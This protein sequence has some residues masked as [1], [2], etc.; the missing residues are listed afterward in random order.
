MHPRGFGFVTVND[1]TF[2]Q[3]VFIP[4]HLTKGAMHGD[5]VEISTSPSVKKNKGPE[6]AVLFVIERAQKELIG[7]IVSIEKNKNII[8]YVH[9][10]GPKRKVRMDLEQTDAYQIADRIIM[11]ILD[12]GDEEK[13]LLCAPLTNMGSINKPS[14]D[15]PAAIKEFNLRCEFSK[16]I[17][18]EAKSFGKKVTRKERSEREDFTKLECFTI[19]PDT[20]KDFDDALSIIKE[21]NGHYTL[22]VHIADVSHYVT[23][24]SS[25]DEEARKRCN[26]TYLPGTCVPM[27][28]EML[29][30][31]L[32]SLKEKVVR[33][34]I[35]VIINFDSE[36]NLLH[37]AIKRGSIYSQKRFTY[38]EAKQVLDGKVKSKHHDSLQKMAELCLLLKKKR[39]ERGCIDLALPEVSF[40][41][42]ASG[43]PRDYKI[44]EYDI[45]H[46]L[47]EE[48]MLKANEIVAS[49]LIKKGK[50]AI[51]RIHEHP[52][53]DNLNEFYALVRTFGFSLPASPKTE[54][55]Q[56]LF[57]QAKGGP[58]EQQV[59]VAFV[60]SMKLAVYSDQNVGHYGL[61]LENYCHFTSPIRRYTDLI[62]HR[63]LFDKQED[64]NLTQIATECSDQERVSFR[65]ESSVLHL[66]KLRYFNEI[67]KKNPNNKYIGTLTR[68]KP[69][70]LFFE[71]TPIQLEGFIHISEIGKD[72]FEY[73]EKTQTLQ[74]RS[75]G[76]KFRLGDRIEVTLE[77]IDLIF[78]T[79]EWNLVIEPSQKYRKKK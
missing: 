34:C 40:Q 8:L 29:S 76:K 21:E 5:L 16:N 77:K 38:S 39:A 35:S 52:A 45:T 22:G 58:Y 15:I 62:I 33:L 20:A 13:P 24:G 28:P 31:H 66:K 63:L 10:L 12:W 11:E 48:F 26:S 70:G 61:S 54:D 27:L 71:L 79:S 41:I 64:L 7:T 57:A 42:D 78:Q 1:K 59:S 19:D 6:G 47:V 2:T 68:I 37:Y 32:C 14:S 23:P 60:R 3:D 73:L 53:N 74:G 51:F 25:L 17:L 18:K 69:F 72:Y 9:S 67:H 75:T 55:L 4:K 30:N 50:G 36:G 46:Q 44:V 65:A 43:I 49:E 56:K